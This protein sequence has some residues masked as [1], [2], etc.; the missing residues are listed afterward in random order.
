MSMLIMLTNNVAHGGGVQSLTEE[1]LKEVEHNLP[2]GMA[3][4]AEGLTELAHRGAFSRL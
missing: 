3:S 2:P 4:E 1:I